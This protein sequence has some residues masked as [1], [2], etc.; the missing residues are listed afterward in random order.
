[1]PDSGTLPYA[2][3]NRGGLTYDELFSDLNFS[4]PKKPEHEIR[5]LSPTHAQKIRPNPPLLYNT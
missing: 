4:S 5:S 3:N 2:L 1:M